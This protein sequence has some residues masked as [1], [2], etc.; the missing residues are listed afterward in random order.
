AAAEAWLG[1]VFELFGPESF[2]DK[3]MILRA[4][5]VSSSLGALGKAFYDND[6]GRQ[7]EVMEIIE[8][9]RIN[10]SIGDH[11][12]G[13]AGRVNPTTARFAVGGGKEY[14]YATHRALVEPTSKIGR[15]IRRRIQQAA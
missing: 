12:A 4:T 7:R 15:R 2:R 14:A 6:A 1:S 9:E 8:D 10:W 11:W 3:S 13:I 5:P